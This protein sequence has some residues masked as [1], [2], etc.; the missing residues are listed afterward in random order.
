MCALSNLMHLT[1]KSATYVSLVGVHSIN[2][3]TLLE[4]TCRKLQSA[5]RLPGLIQSSCHCGNQPEESVL[6]CNK[7]VYVKKLVK[8]NFGNDYY[9]HL[10][11]S[12]IIVKYRCQ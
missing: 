3:I 2:Y 12:T 8:D 5:N 6:R 11:I 10:I 4:L 9:G 1:N 7:A